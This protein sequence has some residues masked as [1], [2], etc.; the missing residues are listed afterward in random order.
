MNYRLPSCVS[1]IVV[2][3]L[4]SDFD[5]DW[6]KKDFFHFY[7]EKVGF[8]CK[9]RLQYVHEC[10]DKLFSPYRCAFFCIFLLYFRI[11]F[12]IA[13]TKVAYINSAILTNMLFLTSVSRRIFRRP[14]D[15]SIKSRVSNNFVYSLNS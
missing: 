5:Y 15:S 11:F 4:K 3:I 13:S 7:S 2:L 8:L 1:G 14:L 6:S 10:N 9:I 12:G